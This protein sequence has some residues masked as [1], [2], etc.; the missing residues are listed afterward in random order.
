MPNFT[1]YLCKIKQGMSEMSVSYL[2][3]SSALT[4]CVL[5]FRCFSLF[6]NYTALQSR[7]RSKNEA[8]FR[9]FDPGKI[10]DVR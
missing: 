10:T 7:L 5:D 9:I 4:I 8:K 2:G 6:R 1:L 3:Q